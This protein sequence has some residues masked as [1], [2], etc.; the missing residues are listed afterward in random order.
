V[1]ERMKKIKIGNKMVGKGEPC[2]IIAEAGANHNRDF[3]LAKKIIDEAVASNADAIK[4]QTFSAETLYSTKTPEFDYMKGNIY[5]IIKSIELPRNWQKDLKEYSDSKGIIFMSTPFDRKAVDELAELKIEAFKVA[6]FE[7]VDLE[8]IE[9]IAKKGKPVIIS[10]G[11][12]NLGEIEEAVNTCK[13]SGNDDIILLHCSSNYPSTPDILNL[14][15]IK[16]MR[17]A[18]DC[19]IGYSDHSVGIHLSIAAVTLGASVLEKHFTLDRT[20]KGPDHPFAIEPQELK[21]MIRNI[22]DAE[23]AFGDGIKKRS[24]KEEDMYKKARRSVI[25]ACAI[26]KG[27]VITRE[28]LTV[29]RPGFGIKPKYINHIVG[30]K[31]A[32]NI[33]EDDII[34]WDLV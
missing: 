32:V 9:Y 21:L 30:R 28:M 22:R 26:P 25:A 3:D 19:V 12:C 2:F 8:F 11:L 16:T 10:T 18:F 6:S 24:D 15:A 5:D 17:K 1:D 4:F 31:A 27:T 29:K 33:E 14:K 34:T 20:M 13:N 7:I 23:L